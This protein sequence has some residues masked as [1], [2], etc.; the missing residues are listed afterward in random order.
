M[1]RCSHCRRGAVTH[2]NLRACAAKRRRIVIRLCRECDADLNEFMLNYGR[3]PGRYKMIARY[4]K[5][6]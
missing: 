5:Q 4:R 6:P 2:W 3:V 1:R